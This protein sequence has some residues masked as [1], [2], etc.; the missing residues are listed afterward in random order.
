MKPLS[1]ETV[2]AV[3][4]TV[5]P[6]I[7]KYSGSRFVSDGIIDSLDIMNLIVALETEFEFDIDPVDVVT[8]TFESV[9][10]ITAMCE[11][12]R[13]ESTNV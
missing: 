7:K 4:E 5:K 12:S 13:K 1:H 3:L 6:D 9:E 11:K 10:S 2:I 8:A